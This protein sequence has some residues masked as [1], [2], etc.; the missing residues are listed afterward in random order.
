MRRRVHYYGDAATGEHL[1]QGRTV[2]INQ[3]QV[4]DSGVYVP[5]F[6]EVQSLFAA[7]GWTD[8]PAAGVYNGERQVQGDERLILGHED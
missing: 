8:D 2:T 1:H 3:I 5:G 7:R 4:Q 6:K